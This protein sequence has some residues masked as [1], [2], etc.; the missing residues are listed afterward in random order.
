MLPALRISA[1]RR[2]ASSP[3]EVTGHSVP[4]EDGTILNAWVGAEY[5]SS[6]TSVGMMIAVGARSAWAVRMARSSTLGSCS[7]TVTIWTYSL[8]TSL[9][10]ESRSTSCWYEPPIALRLVWPTIATT[11]T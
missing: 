11:G 5:S 10:S 1:A 6:C 9:N 8:A 2:I 7:G 4:I 3:A